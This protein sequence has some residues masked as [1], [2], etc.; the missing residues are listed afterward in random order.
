MNLIDALG[1]ITEDLLDIDSVVA[2]FN[3]SLITRAIAAADT[4]N[5]LRRTVT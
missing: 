1:V 5:R 2:N 3:E 4:Q